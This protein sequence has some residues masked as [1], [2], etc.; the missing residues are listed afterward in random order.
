M[1]RAKFFSKAGHLTG[2]SVSG[3]AGYADAGQDIVCSAVSA[4]TTATANGLTEV[5]GIAAKVSDD[6]RTL[7]C[8]VPEN[9]AGRQREDAQLLFDTLEMALS[10]IRDNHRQYL[11]ISDR[12]V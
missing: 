8:L 5:A 2:F 6:G 10:G 1:I 7:R 11:K 3:H 9:V 12:E 4:L